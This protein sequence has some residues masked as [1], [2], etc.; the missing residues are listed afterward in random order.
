MEHCEEHSGLVVKVDTLTAMVKDG[1][2]KITT[3]MDEV[4]SDL[5][6]SKIIDAVQKVENKWRFRALSM[7]WGATGGT[8]VFGIIKVISYFMGR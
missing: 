1:F 5:N 2:E 7:G 3:K 8:G 4:H 6:N